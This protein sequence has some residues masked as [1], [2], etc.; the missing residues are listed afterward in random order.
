MARLNIALSAQQQQAT[1][2]FPKAT[3]ILLAYII[4][5]NKALLFLETLE[6][7]EISCREKVDMFALLTDFILKDIQVS[8]V[9]F[10]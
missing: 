5:K 10:H 2:F 3:A 4:Y 9:T 6:N 8:D 1:G 7:L